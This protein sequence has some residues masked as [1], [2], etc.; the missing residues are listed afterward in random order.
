MDYWF[1]KTTPANT[2]KINALETELKLCSGVI[3]RVWLFHPE[4]CHGLAHASIWIGGHQLYPA[5]PDNDYHGNAV[6]MEFEDQFELETPALLKLITWNEDETY[7]HRVYVRITITRPDEDQKTGET[8]K[9][10]Q[11]LLNTILG[12]SQL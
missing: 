1:D 5:G 7:E 8:N 2:A 4:G 10:L 3:T 6:P 11:E 12:G 9:I